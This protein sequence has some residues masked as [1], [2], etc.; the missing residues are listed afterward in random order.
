MKRARALV[1]LFCALAGSA[2]YVVAQT[3]PDFSGTWV[4]DA[5][6]TA[7]AAGRSGSGRAGAP[8]TIKQDADVLTSIRTNGEKTVYRFDGTAVRNALPPASPTRG[9]SPAAAPGSYETSK[10]S[11]QGAKLVT[12]LTGTGPNGP[13]EATESRW[14][15][16]QWMVTETTRKTPTGDTTRRTYWKRVKTSSPPAL[17]P[18][19]QRKPT[20][21]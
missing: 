8:I 5:E 11:W 9:T 18:N 15:E 14:M 4:V 10:S 17:R 13:T 6:K 12:I 19:P 16:G 21:R 1:L 7:A 2:S 20:R 3:H